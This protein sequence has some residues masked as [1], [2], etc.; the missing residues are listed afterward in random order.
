MIPANINY[1]AP[2]PLIKGLQDGRVQ[3]VVENMRY[4]GG[5]IAV[6]NLG[7]GGYHVHT[8]LSPHKKPKMIH[9]MAMNKM[10]LFVYAGELHLGWYPT[11]RGLHKSRF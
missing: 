9:Y 7:L 6:N 4:W 3:V 5:L 1:S 10:R 2:N 11:K 8:V